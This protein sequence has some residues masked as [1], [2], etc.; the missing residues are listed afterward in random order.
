M[1][2]ISLSIVLLTEG[3]GTRLPALVAECLAVAERYSADHELIIV[4]DG[5]GAESAKQADQLA[6]A[7][8]AVAV[9]HYPRQR[10]YRFA[11]RDAWSVARGD[12]LLTLDGSASPADLSRLLPATP[13]NAVIVGYRA[14][15]PL[16]P[17]TQ[18][19]GLAVRWRIA[20]GLR[21]PAL[22]FAL[23][24]ADLR[25]A[26]PAE[27]SD[28][29]VHAQLYA[30][31]RRRGLSVIQIAVAGRRGPVGSLPLGAVLDALRAPA[32][33]GGLTLAPNNRARQS[34]TLGGAMLLVAGGLWLLRRWLPG[35]RHE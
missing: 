15:P 20:S 3:L 4:D 21:D 16:W 13:E 8:A 27:G 26:L 14:R 32:P 11:L 12:Y 5:G 33:L 29:L 30:E 7:H 31:A 17:I 19:F 10:G 28:L 1:N 2:Q 9:L 22:R 6:A 35:G 18:L 24:R 23:L 34:A 25:D